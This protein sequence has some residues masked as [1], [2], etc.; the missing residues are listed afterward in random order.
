M[1]II[2]ADELNK[3]PIRLN[4]YDKEHGDEKYVFGVEA[5]L[6]YAEYLPTIDAVPV[7]RCRDCRHGIVDDEDF[8][9]QYLCNHNG[10]DWNCGE[11]YCSYGERR[12][13]NA[14]N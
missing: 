5:V 13:K 3:F 12:E 8:P 6:E 4:H 1:R 7:V 14:D 9:N 11:H 2:D 10:C